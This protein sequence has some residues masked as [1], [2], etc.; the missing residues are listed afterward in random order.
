MS[1]HWLVLQSEDVNFVTQL[2]RWSLNHTSHNNHTIPNTKKNTN[3]KLTKKKATLAP[4]RSARQ[5]S[6]SRQGLLN[7]IG[8]GARLRG[9]APLVP[10]LTT[11]PANRCARDYAIALSNPFD[12]DPS[13]PVCYP[14]SMA[15]PSYKL[16]VR[17]TGTFKVSAV[18]GNNVGRGGIAVWPYRMLTSDIFATGVPVYYP[19]IIA[20]DDTYNQA[21]YSFANTGTVPAGSPLGIYA[22]YNSPLTLA[23][24]AAGSGRATRLV[25]CGLRVAYDGKVLDTAGKYVLYRHSYPTNGLPATRDAVQDLTAIPSTTY[26]QISIGDKPTVS[27]MPLL[28]SDH[29]Y[30]GDA[31]TTYATAGSYSIVNR[32]G[33]AVFIENAVAGASFSFEV[34]AYFEVIGRWP[35]LTPTHSAPAAVGP[36]A[37]AVAN[38]APGRL[39]APGA[40]T[41]VVDAA[42]RAIGIVSGEMRRRALRGAA[43]YMADALLPSMA[44]PVAGLLEYHPG[45]H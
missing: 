4:K 21:D 3:N 19:A 7:T 34:I 27:F 14:G 30:S 38:H 41:A 16:R 37:A 22:G 24:L 15:P 42:S 18:A 35:S 33:P 36:L 40:A 25:A 26:T 20:T 1:W 9:Q 31:T 6:S 39:S 28:E 43:R 23:D 11:T 32:M 12:L 5:V 17:T 44:R 45:S 13:T 10:Q 8:K 29:F 2:E